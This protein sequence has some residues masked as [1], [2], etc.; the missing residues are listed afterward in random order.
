M[1]MNI[2][3]ENR[4]LLEALSFIDDSIVSDML[5]EI[6]VPDA[7]SPERNKKVTRR[8]LRYFLTLAAC[9]MLLIAAVP[10]ITYFVPRIGIILDRKS[11]V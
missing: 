8:S 2:K 6:K 3:P 10:I 5:A 1:S 4:R 9:L 7:P 11:V